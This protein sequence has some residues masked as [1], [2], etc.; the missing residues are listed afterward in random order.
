MG[1]NIIG[2]NSSNAKRVA[3]TTD[4]EALYNYLSGTLG[5]DFVINGYGE[6]LGP[7]ANRPW[8]LTGTGSVTEY[9]QNDGVFID[10]CGWPM[11]YL[12]SSKGVVSNPGPSGFQ[13]F[14]KELGYTWLSDA[15]FQSPTHI[16]FS[17]SGYPF[18]RGFKEAGSLNGL[19]LPHGTYQPADQQYFGGAVWELNSG[20]NSSML[21]IHRPGIGWYFYGTS[22]YSTLTTILGNGGTP[23]T[24][25]VNI[26]GAF[27]ERCVHGQT[28]ASG[29]GFSFT[30]SHEP[31]TVAATA[32]QKNTTGPS[33]PYGG[34]SSP[35]PSGGTSTSGSGSG[36]S[37]GSSSSASSSGQGGSAATTEPATVSGLPKWVLPAG[38]I[39]ALGLGAGLIGWAGHKEG[40]WSKNV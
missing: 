3:P 27:I 17:S 4:L 18:D 28:S 22:Y 16:G 37:S 34:S 36:S 20:G 7:S 26:Y 33:S 29:S 38:G 6:A 15:S 12:V 40:W 39:A 10:Y 11:S 30:I 35:G 9:V 5:V 13:L 8:T 23:N 24:I 32:P 21:G 1:G 2:L 14:A 25:P 19:Y 31:Y